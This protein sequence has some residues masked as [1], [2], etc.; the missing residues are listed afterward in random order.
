MTELERRF[1][2]AYLTTFNATAAY[3]DAAGKVSRSTARVNGHR[4]L[5]DPEVQA[6]IKAE[7]DRHLNEAALT[8]QQTLAKLRQFLMYNIRNL[9]DERG[10]LKPMNEWPPVEAAAVISVKDTQWGREVK[11]V[12]K[13]AALEKAMKYHGLFSQDNKQKGEAIAEVMWSFVS[14]DGRREPAPR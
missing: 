3:L 7:C 12:D 14:A 4:L 6:L 5:K 8:V 13:V 11:L 10:N 1:A 2:I 9:F